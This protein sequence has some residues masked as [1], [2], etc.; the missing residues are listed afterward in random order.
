MRGGGPDRAVGLSNYALTYLLTYLLTTLLL[1]TVRGG[2]PDRA[3]AP[4]P[5]GGRARALHLNTRLYGVRPAIKPHV[6]APVLVKSVETGETAET[7]LLVDWRV[8]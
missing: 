4:Q 8:A 2:G 6:R 1:T 7:T 3:L 5:A